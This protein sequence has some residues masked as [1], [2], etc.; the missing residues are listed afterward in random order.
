V[1][2]GPFDPI[3]GISLARCAEL[4]AAVIQVSDGKVCVAMQNGQQHWVPENAVSR[5]A[6]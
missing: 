5:P 3:H 6:A 1:R 2:S 4:G